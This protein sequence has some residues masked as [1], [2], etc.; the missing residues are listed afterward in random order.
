MMDEEV[1]EWR[2]LT[3]SQR[4]G[5][6]PLP[7]PLQAGKLS[8]KFKLKAWR[9]IETHINNCTATLFEAIGFGAE[10]EFDK[11]EDGIFWEEFVFSY[12][13]DVLEMP[14]DQINI[15]KADN[16]KKWMKEIVFEKESHELL[17]LLERMLRFSDIPNEL[18]C[19]IE[20]TF[21]LSPY[22][23]DSTAQPICIV[24][25]TSTEMKESVK[26]SLDN[27]NQSELTGAKVH[28]RKAAEELNAQNFSGS[29]RESIHAVEAAACSIDPKASKD[30]GPALHSLEKHGILKHSALK[31]SFKKL[32]SYTSDEKGIR[33]SLLDKKSADVGFDETIFL[34]G[35]CVAFVDYLVSKQRQ[36][37]GK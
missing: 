30:L 26:K 33:H 4:E 25:V 28:L 16:V 12:H 23:V 10:G 15:K 7:E 3:F 1:K 8:K 27:I 9:V 29:I 35:A 32:Y 6:A 37:N 18:S 24:P 5:K 34:Y 36:L 14:H 31:E 21:E 13:I 22:L 2:E 11:N 20:S 17:T 19:D